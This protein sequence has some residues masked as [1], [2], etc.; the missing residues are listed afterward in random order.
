MQV[1]RS[2][3]ADR[4][5]RNGPDAGGNYYRNGQTGENVNAGLPINR[6]PQEHV[7]FRRFG[8][9]SSIT[10]KHV[11]FQVHPAELKRGN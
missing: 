1:G 2:S 11:F 8:R 5:E 7:Q 4:Y 6:P 9:R 3:R 10:E